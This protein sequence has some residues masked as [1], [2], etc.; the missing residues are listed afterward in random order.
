MS[1]HLVSDNSGL[2]D[3]PIE[4]RCVKKTQLQRLQTMIGCSHC[5]WPSAGAG[6]WQWR[7]TQMEQLLAHGWE[8]RERLGFHNPL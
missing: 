3:L 7:G 2:L 1:S 6:G 4:S 8:A 5:F